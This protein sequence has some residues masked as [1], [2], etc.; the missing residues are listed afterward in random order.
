MGEGGERTI[1]AGR[2]HK[3]RAFSL[4]FPPPPLFFWREK[5]EGG[6]RRVRGTAAAAAGIISKTHTH[7]AATESRAG[8][9]KKGEKNR[10]GC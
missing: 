7:T 2:R 3:A 6:K 4:I 8:H 5:N 9:G 1:Y 10:G